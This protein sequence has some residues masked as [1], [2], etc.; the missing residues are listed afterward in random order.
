MGG[1]AKRV[2]ELA[3]VV[4]EERPEKLRHCEGDILPVPV[5]LVL[6]LGDPRL[7]A[8]EAATVAGLGLA[9]LSESANSQANCSNN[10]E[11]PWCMVFR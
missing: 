11:P 9:E 5:G 10:V 2:I 8:S 3:I 4:V 7:G 6:L 1:A